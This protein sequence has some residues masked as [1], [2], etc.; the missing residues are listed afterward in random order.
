MD[1]RKVKGSSLH[2]NLIGSQ[3]SLS[4]S[5]S[6]R[7]RLSTDELLSRNNSSLLAGKI[8]SSQNE[9]KSLNDDIFSEKDCESQK[10]NQKEN[11]IRG[12]PSSRKRKLPSPDDDDLGLPLAESTV[13]K[14]RRDNSNITQ[15]QYENN[16]QGTSSNASSSTQ[17]PTRENVDNVL[18]EKCKFIK[19]LHESGIK[20]NP[21]APHILC[22]DIIIVQKKMKQLLNSNK[23]EKS[24][25]ITLMEK[26]FENEEN[27]KN[28]LIDMEVLDTNEVANI[29]HTSCLV[30]ILLQV[31]ELHPEI[32]SSLLTKLN[33]AVLIAD[34]MESVPWALLL[35]QQFRFLDVV[36]NSDALTSSLEQLLESCPLW[37]QTELITFLPDI[38]TDKQHQTVA[39]ILNKLLEENTVLVK[40]VLNCMTNLNLGKEYLEE[41]KDKTLN[42]L[43]TNVKVNAIPA[44]VKFVLEDYSNIDIFEK[45]LKVLRDTDMQPLVGED[46]EECYQNQLDVFNNLKMNMLFSKNVINTT[47]AVIKDITKDPKTLDI[48][49]LLLIFQ[50]TDIKRKLVETIFKQHIRSGFYRAS[51]LNMLY[52][53]YKHVVQEL[54]ST[55]LQISSNLLK[56]DE[57]VFTDFAIDWIRLQFKC[58]KNNIF[59]Q[60]E[61]LE[62]IIFLMGDNDQTVKN[63]LLF[64]CKMVEK[65]EDREYLLSHCN[66]LRILLEKM[67]NLNLEEV[68]TLNDLLQHLCTN[69]SATADSLHDDLSI[70]MQKQLSN[71][72]PLTKSKGVLAAVMAIKH[73][74]QKTEVSDIA[75][76]LFKTVLNNVNNCPRSQALFYDQLSSII[77]ETKNVNTDFIKSLADHIEEQFVN[78]NMINK[79]NYRGDSVPKFGL[80]KS[81]D[82][83]R[84]CFITF[85]N[86]K[87]GAIVPISFKLL[88]TCHIRLSENKDL[89]AINSLL[90]CAILMPES[91]DI[92]ENSIV[93]LVICCINWFR[94]VISGFVIQKNPLLRK[95]VLQ[96]LDNLIDLQTELS[97]LL[98]LCD[99]KYQPPPCY[100]HKF[101]LPPFFGIDKKIGKKGKKGKKKSLSFS[102]IK[103]WE[104]GFLICSKNPIYFR[105][106]DASIVH[107][108]DVKMDI[109]VSQSVRHG[110][111]V[112]QVC[113]IVQ[114]L[115]AILE[116]DTN[117]KCIKD[118]IELLPKICA[119]LRDIVE[120]LREEKDNQSREA[121]RLLL[122]LL[123]KI[124]TWKGFESVTYNILLREGLRILASQIDENNIT[125]R[126]CKE[127]VTESCKY[128]ESLSDIATQ[129]SLST[130]LIDMCQSLMK[131]SESYTKENKEK[132]AK[133]AFGFLCLQWPEDNH[134]STQY[135]SAVVQLLNHWINNEPLPLQVITS[136]LEWLPDEIL[137]LE[138]SRNSLSRI[139]SITKANFHSLFKKIFDGLISGIKIALEMA[140]RDPKRIELWY[141][142]GINVQK[143]VQICKTLTTKNNLLIFIKQM[144]ILLKSFLHLGMPVLEHNLKYQTEEVTKI[145]KMMQDGTRY[146]HRIC[147]DSAEKKDTTLMKYIPAAKSVLEKLIFCV[148]GMLVLNN[149]PAAFW[150]G[151]LVN[152]NLEGQEIFSQN[153]S[154]EDSSSIQNI[155]DT[156]DDATNISSDILASDSD[157]VADDDDV[158]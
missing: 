64:L 128:F 151:N 41:F 22:K 85:E 113:F 34:S 136:I 133:M 2:K 104:T 114:E 39:E 3:T 155:G 38:V 43:K 18:I 66:H 101:P 61:I 109:H 35:L 150:M 23:Y 15:S 40:S 121:A 78:T 129:I 14:K 12:K 1:R 145:L 28:A 149:S 116:H 80:N 42:L 98:T 9:D 31:S 119:K 30:K 71:F 11:L 112:K 20:I 49:L 73:L 143:L 141:E 59:K 115:L 87:Y 156:L 7:T 158:L 36:I 60:R 148:K 122:R 146:L 95:Q 21:N 51:L 132:Y 83:P 144:S 135:K 127:L 63:T 54:Q 138:K 142:V 100:F 25:L 92:A 44:I 4:S 124:F 94:E 102:E 16:N 139:P 10:S 157:D 67:D 5:S 107:L 84:N 52:N 75:Y 89:G 105:K 69:S 26:Y 96:R 153:I 76:N 110:I 140:D 120:T 118:L 48:I 32:Y 57:R 74:M 62:R 134:S 65:E 131:H 72:K 147:C 90:G 55:V 108:L 24:E 117:E 56:T 93:D 103:D 82:E 68:G 137:N 99:T 53:D 58:H 111:S 154:S 130:S 8:L 46:A 126:S 17:I 97:T 45:A 86:K 33:E 19:F 50:T 123:T 37:F 77:L 81:E 79:T 91:L 152:K 70:L 125:L 106:F 47:L 27:L 6:C 13:L 88:R 29:L